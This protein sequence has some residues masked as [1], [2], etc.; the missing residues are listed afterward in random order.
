[1]PHGGLGELSDRD[2]TLKL[3]DGRSLGYRRYGD[4]HGVP[5]FYFHGF[6]GSRLEAGF[7]PVDGLSLIAVE[8]PGYG[9]SDPMRRRRLSDWPTD[10]AALADHLGFER[11]SVLGVSGGAPY[12][13]ACAWAMPERVSA[14]ALVCGIGPPAAPGMNGGRMRELQRFGRIGHILSPIVD[15]ARRALVN[16]HSETR[17]I[18]MRDQLISRRYSGVPRERDAITIDFMRH[19]FGV[20]REA[21]RR[22]V[23]GLVSD[24]RIYTEAWPFDLRAI[25]VPVHLWHGEE[26]FIVPV[27]VGKHY[28][29]HVPGIKARILPGEGHFSVILNSLP[30]II[31]TLIAS[32]RP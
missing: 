23:R 25:G 19:M 21:L 28:A 15:L 14:A 18:A 16:G 11:F 13:A 31:E 6:P 32:T 1:M 24:A 29:A 26:D 17:I 27:D 3:A 22:S 2:G 10:I 7:V 8:R 20:W 9:L 4:T 12:A 5:V 30:E